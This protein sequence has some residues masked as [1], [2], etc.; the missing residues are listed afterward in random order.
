[1]T[2]FGLVHGAYH[3]GASWEQLERELQARGHEAISM[4]LPCDK[5]DAGIDDYASA[6]LDALRDA[7]DDVVVVGHSMGGL[8]IPVVAARRPVGRLVFLAALVVEPGRSLGDV[9]GEHPDA[10]NVEM[11]TAG[12]DNGNSTASMPVDAA[13]RLF[14]E[15]CSAD[16]AQWAASLLRPQG[17]KPSSEPTPIAAWPDVPCTYIACQDDRTLT[18]DFQRHLA[19]V[20][21][22]DL[23]ELPG[24]HSPFVARPAELAD[25]LASL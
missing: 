2:T 16:A 23:V 17:W 9:L 12:I 5:P 6:V 3:G 24:S 21:G 4:D 15:D 11:M 8:T 1:V 18:I 14:Y 13:L 7:P 25:L 20:H 22:M 19:K 10:I